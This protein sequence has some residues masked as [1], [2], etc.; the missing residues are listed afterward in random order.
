MADSGV[1]VTPSP[2]HG[3]LNSVIGGLKVDLKNVKN[4]YGR[5]VDY[6][7]DSEDHLGT[8]L[9]DEKGRQSFNIKMFDKYKLIQYYLEH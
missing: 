7:H 9:N 8:F 5:R 6:Q 4:D 2:S 3:H 1:T